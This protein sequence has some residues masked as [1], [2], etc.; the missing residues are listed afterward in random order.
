MPHTTRRHL[1][2]ALS[3]LTQLASLVALASLSLGVAACGSNPDVVNGKPNNG[4]DDAG[5]MPG[6]MPD[7]GGPDLNLDSGSDAGNTSDADTTPEA[8]P[9][10]G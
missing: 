5:M 8:G 9:A 2:G 1:F 6:D 10:K 3:R 4:N 7:S